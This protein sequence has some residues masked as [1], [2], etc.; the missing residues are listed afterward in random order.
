MTQLG[1][2]WRQNHVCSQSFLGSFY[3]VRKVVKVTRFCTW[4]ER[5]ETGEHT[6]GVQAATLCLQLRK[7]RS[8]HEIIGEPIKSENS[9]SCQVLF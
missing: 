8:G 3:R 7:Q 9:Q 4:T 1:G 2:L 5:S 6:A